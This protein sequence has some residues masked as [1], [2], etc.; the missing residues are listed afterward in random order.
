LAYGKA[1]VGKNKI[2]FTH[3]KYWILSYLLLL[4]N[5]LFA[6]M[7][8]HAVDSLRSA[9]G[10]PGMALAMITPEGMR[11]VV[12]G[13][14]KFPEGEKLVEAN[15]FHLGSNSKAITA[16]IAAQLIAK[17]KVSKD[18]K[19]ITCLPKLDTIPKV[20]EDVTLYHLLTHQGK[21]RP[22]TSGHEMLGLPVFKG[23]VSERRAQFVAHLLSQE[24]VEVGTYSNAGYAA[25]ALILEYATGRTFEALLQEFMEENGWK[26]TIGWPNLL[27]VSQPW[28]HLEFNGNLIPTP[29][30]HPYRL[31]DVLMPAGDMSM[32]IADYAE[33]VQAMLLGAKGKESK[34]GKVDYQQ[35]LFGREGYSWGW[36]N[37]ANGDAKVVFHDGSV[38]TFYCHAILIP[39]RQVGFVGIIN[40]AKASHVQ[41]LFEIRKEM[42]DQYMRNKP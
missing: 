30:D 1:E 13:V 18:T 24:A 32:P 40:S 29:A 17:G 42:L 38:G 20:Y 9:A 37:Q 25:A 16:V 3:M 35:L 15:F 21:V 28:G 31:M 26:Y 6:Q 5:A 34:L 8:T 33:F 14:N 2:N 7:D 10:I 23:T 22:Y 12:L 41:V 27:D 19:L 11:H 39:D 36:G 4:N